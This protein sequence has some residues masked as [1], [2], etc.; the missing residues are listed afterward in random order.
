MRIRGELSRYITPI[1]LLLML[2]LLL[3]PGGKD[4]LEKIRE[5]KQG[6]KKQA[7]VIEEIAEQPTAQEVAPNFIGLTE[8][9]K[10]R[11]NFGAH[12]ERRILQ[13]L[14]TETVLLE[15]LA[16]KNTAAKWLLDESLVLN[17]RW[18]LA[19]YIANQHAGQALIQFEI[20]G[21]GSQAKFSWKLIAE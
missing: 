16:G 13:A 21:T 7:T 11:L 3:L 17:N 19:T 10:R 15:E 6:K 20:E 12:P 8:A 2:S 4:G 9:D 1:V 5:I 18:L 14:A